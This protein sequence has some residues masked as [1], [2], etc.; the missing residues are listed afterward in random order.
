MIWRLKSRRL[1]WREAATGYALLGPS[2]A[3][4]GL[5]LIFPVF[6]VLGLS[7][8]EWDLIS[9][10]R[11]VGLDNLRDVFTDP[12]IINS[13]LVT[14]LFVLLVIPTQ[15]VLGL[16]IA[17][18][19]NQ[20]L[21]GSS[22]FRVIYVIPWIS[23]PLAMGVVWR[24]I[25]DPSDGAL[26]ALLGQRVEWLTSPA[27]ALP[28]VAAVAVWTQ[29]GYVALFFLAGLNAIP[30]QIYEAAQID[31][32]STRQVFWRITLPLLRPTTY[33][34]LVTGVI[35]SFQVFDTVYAM[36]R[37]GPAGRTDV[38]ASRIY[39]EAFEALRLGRAA[40]IALVLFVLLIGITLAQ[41]LYFRRR[42]T[43]EL[44]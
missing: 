1:A 19:L 32:A 22:V 17:L 27:L 2:L 16:G 21:R 25:F 29:M 14:L 3:G 35:A 12:D 26:N 24:W 7:L 18:L 8:Q 13:F 4:V 36:T 31:G 15:T 34:V 10:A 5:F 33:F 11:W 44:T 38:V 6:V 40:A 39:F 37:G 23:A 42:I 20:R 43:Y 28:A 9:P 30:G 41:H